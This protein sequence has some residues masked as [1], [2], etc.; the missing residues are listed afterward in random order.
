MEEKQIEEY[1]KKLMDMREEL[2]AELKNSQEA[3][4]E[5]ADGEVP[6][7]GDVSSATYNRDVLFSLGETQRQMLRDI[8]EALD[9]L[10]QGE[11]ATC[12]S[13]GEDIAPKRMEVRPF[14]RYCIDCKTDVERFGER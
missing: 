8:D 14:S 5:Y 2:L 7:I 6:D 11:Y 3:S 12:Q 9:L 4:R 13:C 10:E 1:R